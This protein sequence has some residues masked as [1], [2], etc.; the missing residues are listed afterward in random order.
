MAAHLE[1]TTH[2]PPLRCVVL[3]RVEGES[4]AI[5]P[6]GDAAFAC[7]GLALKGH[8]PRSYDAALMTAYA[9]TQPANDPRH[10]DAH[11]PSRDSASREGTASADA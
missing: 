9:V 10:D 1:S 11:V 8:L 5:R 6:V 7:A 3:A 4:G 2:D